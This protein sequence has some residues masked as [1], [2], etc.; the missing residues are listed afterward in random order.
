MRVSRRSFLGGSIAS[1]GLLFGG[2]GWREEDPLLLDR[3]VTA[4]EVLES[5]VRGE[6]SWSEFHEERGFTLG[7]DREKYKAL[8]GKDPWASTEGLERD[9]EI[10]EAGV[11]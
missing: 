5:F 10:L 3:P 1:I 4:T 11:G 6:M 2:I 8:M 7:V 9:R